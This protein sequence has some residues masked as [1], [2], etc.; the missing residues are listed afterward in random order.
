MIGHI[1]HETVNSPNTEAEVLD[2]ILGLDPQKVQIVKQMS[3]GHS[4]KYRTHRFSKNSPLKSDEITADA[5][6]EVDNDDEIS[7][8]AVEQAFTSVKVGEA[9]ETTNYGSS[10]LASIHRSQ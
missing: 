8:L 5:Y 2:E 6:S 9:K 10:S 7:G 4:T 1:M 3:R